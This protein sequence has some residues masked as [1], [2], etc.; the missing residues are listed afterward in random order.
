MLRLAV[1]H[2]PMCSGK[3]NAMIQTALALPSYAPRVVLSSVVDTR[4]P[5]SFLVS[6]T[7]ATLAVTARVR[8]LEGIAA[9]R[10]THYVLD[11]SQFFREGE[12]LRFARDVVAVNAGGGGGALLAAGLDRDFRG[13]AFGDVLDLA[14]LA[15]ELGPARGGLS[16]PLTAR[17]CWRERGS[18]GAPCG[19]I[20]V[21]TQKLSAAK[22]KVEK[23]GDVARIRVGGA[24]YYR[25]A[26][27]RHHSV[28]PCDSD[29]WALAA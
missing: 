19:A 20:A 5:P 27:A 12:A 15:W 6:R 3:T 14:A 7:G 23:E 29:S 26:C 28:V 17:C 10:G 9:E 1:F 22:G 21:F 13:E 25:P 2:G 16:I 8:S 24:E 18:T 11:E 4:S